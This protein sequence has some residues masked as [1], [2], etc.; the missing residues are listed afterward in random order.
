MEV[1]VQTPGGLRREL[2]V[3]V[4]ADRV[5]KAYNERLRKLAARARIP[6]FR[7]GK[8]PMKVVAQQYGA[9]ARSE[10]IGDLLHETYP[11]A[12][13]KAG[14]EPAGHP[15]F[16]VKAASANAALEYVARIEVYP[17]IEL[18]GLDKLKIEQPEVEVTDADVEK[19]ILSLRT[20]RRSLREVERPARDGDVCTID[21]AGTL[22]GEAFDGGS[23]TDVELEIGKGKFLPDLE[24]GL[25]GHA[26]GEEFSVEVSFPDDYQA[27]N[28]RGRTAQFAVTLK[29]V[30]EPSLPEIDAE[31]LE[32][33]NVDPQAGEAGL[34]EK[35][36]E[37]LQREAGKA[38]KSRLK[39]QV[40]DQ[41]LEYNPIDVPEALIAQE[42]PRLRDEAAQ[43]FNAMNLSAEQK[44]QMLP[45][46][47]FTATAQRRV[48]LGLLIGEVIKTREI[49]LDRQRVE[50]LLD[51]IAADYQ[52][53]E[54]IK[55]YYQGNPQLMQ[56]IHA[57]VMEEQ[58]VESLLDSA[59]LKPKKMSLDELLNPQAPR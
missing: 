39:S 2:H 6:G 29:R 43:R 56:G 57:M 23:G 40:L 37:A 18:R 19:L 41:L 42:I 35:C 33:H 3:S 20:S 36:R 52:N 58:V 30:C 44:S 53:P 15:E 45:D 8:A 34:R 17:E 1:E 11:E 54:Q 51:E 13:S 9:Q 55:Q 4:A 32:A 5:E 31:F 21:F 12:V 16:E 28:L 7:P 26:P 38:I 59:K 48:A 50:Q 27:E 24:Q 25:I 47:L 49:Q 10:V 22:D 14:L 46:A